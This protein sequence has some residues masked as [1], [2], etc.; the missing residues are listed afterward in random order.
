MPRRSTASFPRKLSPHGVNPS[1]TSA[2][3]PKVDLTENK[4]MIE[5]QDE[6]RR[7]LSEA[8]R[9][10]ASSA[11]RIDKTRELIERTLALVSGE[12]KT[13]RGVPGV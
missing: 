10:V 9:L 12:T 2:L 1:V 4:V 13:L 6:G 5:F 3:N 11:T 7:N 8:R